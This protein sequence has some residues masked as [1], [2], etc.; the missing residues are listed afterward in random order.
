MSASRKRLFNR[1]QTMI[2]HAVMSNTPKVYKFVPVRPNL[3]GR[4]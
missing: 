4:A 3:K 1:Q 2:A